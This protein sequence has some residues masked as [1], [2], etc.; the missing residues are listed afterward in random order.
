MKLV[1]TRLV[2]LPVMLACGLA[3]HAQDHQDGERNA[4][5][6]VQVSSDNE[7]FVTRR[8]T[9]EFF[10]TATAQE[11]QFGLKARR[12]DFSQN[13]WTRRGNQFLIAGKSATAA[14]GL[15]WQAE[16][17]VMDQGDHQLATIDGSLRLPLSKTTSVEAFI[18]RD[19]VE[20]TAALNR[21]VHATFA[22]AAIEHAWHPQFTTVALLGHQDFSDGNERQ[23]GRVRLIYQP[24]LDLPLT[25]QLR[26]R[27]FESSG[28]AKRRTY[29]NPEHYEETMALVGWRKHQGKV[30]GSLLAGVGRQNIN[31][32]SSTPTFLLESQLKIAISSSQAISLNAGVNRSASVG[33]PDYRYR[34]AGVSWNVE[35]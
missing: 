2:I 9:G 17:G 26:Y 20:T 16:A 28:E 11:N 34:Y 35:F 4:S 33:G 15:T 30:T 1:Q 21:G 25:L 18:N 19:F 8:Q 6:A 13:G 29:F 3:A 32:E 22:G 23:H 14:T 10:P 5:V 31:R 24:S 7:G 27:Q 12:H